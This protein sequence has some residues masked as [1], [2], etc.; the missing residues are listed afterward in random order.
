MWL[1]FM[2]DNSRV[3]EHL[4]NHLGAIRRHEV[5]RNRTINFFSIIVV[6]GQVSK[7]VLDLVNFSRMLLLRYWM[8]SHRKDVIQSALLSHVKRFQKYDV[9]QT[10]NFSCQ[11]TAAISCCLCRSRAIMSEHHTKRKTWD[12]MVLTLLLFFFERPENQKLP[13]AINI[14]VF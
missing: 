10:K 13:V 14:S 5:T 11:T 8:F 1:S 9:S 7:Q 12:V 2:Q 3:N 4:T 6:V